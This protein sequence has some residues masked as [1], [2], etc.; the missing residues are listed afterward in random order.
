MSDYRPTVIYE[1][2]QNAH[3]LPSNTIGSS[4]DSLIMYTYKYILYII[5]WL[6]ISVGNGIEVGLIRLQ[7]VCV[8]ILLDFMIIVI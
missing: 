8:N 7:C 3:S 6:W 2:F 1:Y 4:C 5:T